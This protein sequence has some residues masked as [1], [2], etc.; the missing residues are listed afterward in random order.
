[1]NYVF[2]SSSLIY[3]GKIKLLEK[4][5]MIPGNKFI[6][7]EVYIEVVEKGLGRNE[8]EAVYI[9]A[10]IKKDIFTIKKVTAAYF[11]E[12]HLSFADASVLNLARELKGMAIIDESYAR[13]IA[14]S[15]GIERRGSLY[16]ILKMVKN[17]LLNKKEAVLYLNAIIDL[18]FYLST[19]KYNEFLNLL[20]RIQA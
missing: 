7:V 1:M 14:K 15:S 19:A 5:G 10:I 17:K 2:D 4:I 18:G 16:I 20:E 9:D 13:N 6:P 12:N 8:P 11:H 3:F